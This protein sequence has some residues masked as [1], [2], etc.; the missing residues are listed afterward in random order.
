MTWYS[1]WQGGW[2]ATMGG[3]RGVGE[4]SR[5]DWAVQRVRAGTSLYAGRQAVV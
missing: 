4:G 5:E 1:A 2:P 3:E